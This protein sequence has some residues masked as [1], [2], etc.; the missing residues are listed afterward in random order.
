V[1][2]LF[3]EFTWI[4]ALIFVAVLIALVAALSRRRSLSANPSR[5][6][7]A[8]E[9]PRLRITRVATALT[10][11]ILIWF[12]IQSARAHDALERTDGSP[13]RVELTGQQWWWRVEYPGRLPSENAITANELHVPVNRRVE[14]VLNSTDVVHSLWIPELAGKRDL[15]PGIE[16]KLSLFVTRPG[17]Y[18]GLCAEFCGAQHAHMG[19]DVVAQTQRDF[20]AW[21][22]AQRAP[23]QEPSTEPR[24][25]GRE[26]FLSSSCPLC[27]TIS[28]TDA[29]ATRGP[30]LTHVASRPSLAATALPNTL[31]SLRAWIEDPQASK[32]GSYMPATRLSPADLDALVAYLESLK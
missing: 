7:P 27:H 30:D 3:Y 17:I 1:L 21:L 4:C 20:D 8:T 9:L 12:L 14:L 10:V 23:A 22:N 24:A 26:V 15:I 6:D 5:P 32:P 11:L 16:G 19:L 2:E 25:R 28:G 29:S 18:R 31:A 13:L